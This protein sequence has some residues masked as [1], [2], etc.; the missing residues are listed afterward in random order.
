MFHRLPG[1]CET[2]IVDALLSIAHETDAIIAGVNGVSHLGAGVANLIDSLRLQD[3]RATLKRE[4]AAWLGP[5]ENQKWQPHITVLNKSTKT[6]ADNLYRN[7]SREFKPHPI[8][9]TGLDLWEYRG[10]SWGQ[11]TY[12][13]FNAPTDIV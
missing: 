10:G 4:F 6:E 8:W 3:V 2:Q 11:K 7:L 13:P 1:A 5:Q 12:V 9:V